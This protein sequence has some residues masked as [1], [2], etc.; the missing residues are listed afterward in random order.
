V[1]LL[2]NKNYIKTFLKRR[3]LGLAET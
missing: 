1:D 3:F 2:Y